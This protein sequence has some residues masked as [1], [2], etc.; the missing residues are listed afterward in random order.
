MIST[1]RVAKIILFVAAVC[2]LVGCASSVPAGSAGADVDVR[3]LVIDGTLEGLDLGSSTA[4]IN[5]SVAPDPTKRFLC[6]VL[7]ETETA[8]FHRNLAEQKRTVL[9]APRII[10]ASG[11][12]ASVQ[13]G[14]GQGVSMK[15]DVTASASDGGT[16]LVKFAYSEG[17]AGHEFSERTFTLN[18]GDSFVALAGANDSTPQSKGMK[19]R[20]ILVSP[21]AVA[22][23]AVAVTR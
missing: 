15:L 20:T 13:V 19:H 7:S 18:P 1:C 4:P 3:V 22:R 2:S 5:F 21:S 14:D 16:L 12:P 17:P 10:A 9:S 11:K 6:A 23:S 8:E